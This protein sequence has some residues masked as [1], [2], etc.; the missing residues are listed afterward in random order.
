[1]IEDIKMEAEFNKA[2]VEGENF[3]EYR[4]ATLTEKGVI[5]AYVITASDFK[6]IE[7]QVESLKLTLDKIQDYVASL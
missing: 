2:P 4:N 1:M 5:K 3:N 6:A 7:A